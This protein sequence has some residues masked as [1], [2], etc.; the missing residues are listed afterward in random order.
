M[1]GENSHGFIPDPNYEGW[2]GV[3]IGIDNPPPLTHNLQKILRYMKSVGK[4]VDELT[5]EEIEKFRINGR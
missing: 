4:T 5:T 1:N 2:D 3:F